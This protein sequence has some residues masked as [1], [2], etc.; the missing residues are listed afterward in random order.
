MRK[1]A[2]GY[3][4]DLTKSRAGGVLEYDMCNSNNLY[5]HL[6]TFSDTR[7]H[8]FHVQHRKEFPEIKFGFRHFDTFS[9]EIFQL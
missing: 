8:K 2:S 9:S 3:R 6:Q 7:S 4:K 5:D 1:H